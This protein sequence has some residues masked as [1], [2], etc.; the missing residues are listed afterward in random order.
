MLIV[1]GVCVCV[2]MYGMYKV[3]ATDG[4]AQLVSL[5]GFLAVVQWLS[6]LVLPLIQVCL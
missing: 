4:S 3:K 1:V 2:A 5:F 6:I